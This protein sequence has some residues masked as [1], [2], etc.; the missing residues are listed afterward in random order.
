D[1][2]YRWRGELLRDGERLTTFDQSTF[3]GTSIAPG[4]VA[5]RSPAFRP[6]LSPRARI[7][8]WILSRL[9]DGASLGEVATELVE[10]EPELHSD[11]HRALRAVSALADRYAISE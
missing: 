4:A 1:Y 6:K 5:S 7:D 10:R 8:S 2:L 3:H 9:S 11:P